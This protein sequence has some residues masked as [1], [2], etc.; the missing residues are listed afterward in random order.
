M[1]EQAQ[2]V[3]DCQA[4]LGGDRASRN[5]REVVARAVSDPASLMAGLGEPTKGGLTIL[6]RAADLTVLNVVWP[7]G[8]I[9]MPHDH[10]VWA[11]IGV[12]T[13]REDNFLWRRMPDSPDGEIEAAGA[14]SLGPGDAVAFGADVVHSVVNPLGR[15]TGAIHVYGG[16]FFAVERS[17]WDQ[18]TLL[19][20]PYDM[21]KV[22]QLF[23]R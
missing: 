22:K 6:H 11:V 5:V 3:S 13:G 4:A 20:R 7:A 18:E 8:L 21:E 9:L 23:A 17:E 10:A 2:F 1:L 16:D 12:Y 19:E 15:M 14:K